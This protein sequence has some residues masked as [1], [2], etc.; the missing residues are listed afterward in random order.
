MLIDSQLFVGLVLI[1]VASAVIGGILVALFIPRG[2]TSNEIAEIKRQ[3]LS[4]LGRRGARA[5]NSKRKQAERQLVLDTAAQM[6]RDMEA[7]GVTIH[8]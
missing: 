7:K 2:P 8:A 5:S 1:A 4:E 3:A 6:R